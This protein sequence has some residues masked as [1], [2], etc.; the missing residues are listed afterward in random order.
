MVTAVGA[1]ARSRVFY[2][3]VK[4]EAEE[5]VNF[6]RRSF[7]RDSSRGPRIN[8]GLK[9]Y[10]HSIPTFVTP[11]C[12]GRRRNRADPA[13]TSCAMPRTMLQQSEPQPL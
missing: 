4:G 8:D 10:T 3:R 7:K 2:S 6:A 5:A 13:A 9:T 1:D 12:R 11:H